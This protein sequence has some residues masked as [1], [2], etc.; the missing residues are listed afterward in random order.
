MHHISLTPFGRQPVTAAHLAAARMAE[1]PAPLPEIDKWALLRELTAARAAFGI[2]DRDLAVLS[3]LL[4]FHPDDC[5]RDGA[6]LVVHPSNARLCARA[7][8]MAE[9]TLRRHLAALV[10]AGL[11]ARRDSPNGKRYVLRGPEGGTAFGFDLR[12]LLVRAPEIAARAQDMRAETARLQGLRTGIV[13]ALRDAAKL[14]AWA[15][16]AGLAHPEHGAVLA[17]EQAELTRALRRRMDCDTATGLAARARALLEA[18]K[19]LV[20]LEKTGEPGGS[21]SQNARHIQDSDRN[22]CESGMQRG[23]P[24]ADAE[25]PALPL[26]LVLKA[27]PEIARYMPDG[28]RRWPDLVAAAETLHPMMDISADAWAEARRVMGPEPA[29]IT[30]ACILQRTGHI[31]RPGGYLRRLSAKAAEGRF[32]PGPMVMALLRG[33]A[34]RA[35]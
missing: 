19:S 30:L 1:A 13:L 15:G 6:A 4:S 26:A 2:G 31:A 22:P 9:S 27:A 33:E 23:K 8:G 11:I 20:A 5:L 34:A 21:D 35:A 32:T 16:E 7:H 12:P 24:Q 28:I 14:L 17:A 29:A 3:A 25:A 10:R 18:V